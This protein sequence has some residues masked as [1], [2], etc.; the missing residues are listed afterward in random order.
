MHSAWAV[1]AG[2]AQEGSRSRR[3]AWPC[4]CKRAEAG[5]RQGRRKA[6]APGLPLSAYGAGGQGAPHRT[7]GKQHTCTRRR[8]RAL[9]GARCVCDP[10][11]AGACPAHPQGGVRQQGGR[12]LICLLKSLPVGIPQL[13]L[14]TVR[15]RQRQH[16][17]RGSDPARLALMLCRA[18]AWAGA[19]PAASDALATFGTEHP[20]LLVLRPQ[21]HQRRHNTAVHGPSPKHPETPLTNRCPTPRCSP[22]TPSCQH[23]LLSAGLTH[24]ARREGLPAAACTA[25]AWTGSQTRRPSPSTAGAGSGSR[26]PA[27]AAW[28]ACSSQTAGSRAARTARGAVQKSGNV[29]AAQPAERLCVR[30]DR[31]SRPGRQGS[32]PSCSSQAIVS[33]S[34]D[35]GD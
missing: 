24:A 26:G 6:P 1:A 32:H 23:F 11:P 15:P 33:G 9:K 8:A 21:P 4:P 10:A 14:R 29:K 35:A 13:L 17:Q 5:H 22:A 12:Q 7:G 2:R 25:S 31:W 20:L 3:D 18:R 28:R 30:T 16:L 34:V 19:A 27:A